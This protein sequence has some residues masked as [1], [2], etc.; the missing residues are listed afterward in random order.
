MDIKPWE[1]HEHDDRGGRSSYPYTEPDILPNFYT[2]VNRTFAHRMYEI[3]A[4]HLYRGMWN[5]YL[6]VW[7]STREDPA[8]IDDIHDTYNIHKE[9]YISEQQAWIVIHTYQRYFLTYVMT[10]VL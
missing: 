1:L 4:R 8:S 7:I 6:N 10:D 3:Y 5:I 2:L 9:E